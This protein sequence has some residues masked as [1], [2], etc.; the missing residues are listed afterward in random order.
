[1]HYSNI[2]PFGLI[3]GLVFLSALSEAE[4]P[5]PDLSRPAEIVR[6]YENCNTICCLST[7][8]ERKR[9]AACIADDSLPPDMRCERLRKVFSRMKQTIGC[10]H[11][12]DARMVYPTP[13]P[14]RLCAVLFRP[15]LFRIRGLS[16]SGGEASVVVATRSLEPEST[17]RF[18]SEY[19]ATGLEPR[20]GAAGWMLGR[21]RSREG[22]ET[23]Q[24]FLSGGRWLK[25]ADHLV[26]LIR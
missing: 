18:I 26:Y 3:L 25:Q 9:I 2:W 13:S 14:S 11:V 24:W 20:P 10:V 17:L 19:E 4:Q 8:E 15:K 7:E 12:Q 5:R 1:M 16:V 21:T 6:F 23:H 22:R